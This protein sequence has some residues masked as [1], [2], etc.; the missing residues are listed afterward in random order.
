MY[1]GHLMRRTQQPELDSRRLIGMTAAF[2]RMDFEAAAGEVSAAGYGAIEVS[3]AH[4]GPGT[5]N[6]PGEPAHARAAGDHLRRQG[7]DPV[8]LSAVD[9]RFDPLRDPTAAVLALM[10]TLQLA[11]ALGAPKVLVWDGIRGQ[12]S[13]VARADAPRVLA[14]CIA[15]AQKQSGLP[16]PPAVA[17][18][19]QPFT[20]ALAEGMVEPTA[21]ALRTVGA[22]ICLDVAHFAVA[23]GPRFA[24]T[25]GSVVMES[26]THV[27]WCDSD[28]RTEGYHLPP[29]AGVVD[30]DALEPLITATPAPIALDLVGWP[31]PR[32]A[33]RDCRAAYHA[34]VSRQATARR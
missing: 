28:C 11:H 23:Y 32:E 14:E 1:L 7:L 26:V 13:A 21:Q 8:A 12:E 29:G 5:V 22:G 17:V 6:V 34:L 31:A 18:E 33:L 2:P 24:R 30:L 10:D 27:H 19:L 20:F 15:A 4:I 9:A 16:L 25:L 3:G